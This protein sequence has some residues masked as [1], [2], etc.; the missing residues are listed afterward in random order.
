MTTT[1]TATT[2]SIPAPIH[3]AATKP[4][5]GGRYAPEGVAH[6][7]RRGLSMLVATCGKALACLPCTTS[8]ADAGLTVLPASALRR[9][10]RTKRN[11]IPSVT[12][13]DAG[14]QTPDG[15]THPVGDE[16]FP[17]VADVIPS[18]TDARVAVSFNAALL[19][20]LAEALGAD[21]GKVIMWVDPANK[22]PAIIVPN[23]SDGIGI[24][25]PCSFESAEAER[26]VAERRLA[27][28]RMAT[29]T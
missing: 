16:V 26:K 27:D 20:S 13:T 28:A 6:Y 9:L 22:Q 1:T 5:M 21:G 11:P 24:I 7:A 17:N 15:L 23:G 14:V 29:R 10:K 3:L 4:G 8:D 25:M 18:Y 12:V 2:V 19:A